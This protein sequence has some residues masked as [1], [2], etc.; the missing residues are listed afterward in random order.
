MS[1]ETEGSNEESLTRLIST[2][3]SKSLMRLIFV[4]IICVTT[5]AADKLAA[6]F[7]LRVSEDGTVERLIKEEDHSVTDLKTLTADVERLKK[8]QE[9]VVT[10][11][12]YIEMQY[13]MYRLKYDFDMMHDEHQRLEALV[14]QRPTFQKQPAPK[15]RPA[16]MPLS[17]FELQVLN[18]NLVDEK[19]IH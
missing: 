19:P 12:S 10:K 3:T 6:V 14:T 11:E 2:L 15:P 7:N 16:P 5:V 9:T 4:L 8:L 17:E 13:Q 1:N 18:G